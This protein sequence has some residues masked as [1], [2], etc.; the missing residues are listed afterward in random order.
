MTRLHRFEDAALSGR[1]ARLRRS[2]ADLEARLEASIANAERS[3]RWAPS[4]P[5]CKRLSLLLRRVRTE[6]SEAE[7]EHARRRLNVSPRVKPLTR[8]G[9]VSSVLGPKVTSPI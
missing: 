4:D 1:L 6:L 3:G 8:N 9:R 2:E 7:R 5:S